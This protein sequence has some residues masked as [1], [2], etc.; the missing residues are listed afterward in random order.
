MSLLLAAA[1][2]LA[3]Q[4]PN[5]AP[6]GSRQFGPFLLGSYPAYNNG[7]QVT[8]LGLLHGEGLESFGLFRPGAVPPTLSPERPLLVLFHIYGGDGDIELESWTEFSDEADARHWYILAP[9][10]DVPSLGLS[11]TSSSLRRKTYGNVDAQD[12]LELTLRW[13]LD[14]YPIDRD[15]I[16]GVGFSMGGG[17]VVSYAAQH[18]DPTRGAFAAVATNAGTLCLTQEYWLNPS[19]REALERAVGG[20]TG[21]TTGNA[22]D[23]ERFSSL[24]YSD[25]SQASSLDLGRRHPI[26]NLARTPLQAWIDTREPSVHLTGFVDDIEVVL[27]APHPGSYFERHDVTGTGDPHRWIT[28]DYGAVCDTFATK[29]LVVPETA[30]LTVS[31]DARY[32]DLWLR[33]I[34]SRA[35]GEVRYDFTQVGVT[36]TLDRV[37]IT[38]CRNIERVRFD[39][40]VLG[41]GMTSFYEVELQRQQPQP[42]RLELQQV[43]QPIFVQLN[44]AS[45]G[46]APGI[47]TYDLAT[48]TLTLHSSAS[49]TDVWTIL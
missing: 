3:P 41:L 13:V 43:S 30:H 8:E 34:D 10:Q 18:L 31:R 29:Q 47:W 48:H 35:F 45:I 14:H 40:G 22:F 37:S 4:T 46:P 42:V 12:R 25:P 38:D 16:Y 27:G 19:S 20:G 26:Q 11:S 6:P 32:W 49:A 2:C 36:G 33:R 28:F 39:G 7:G 21:P 23:Y 9:D 17:D 1:L 44:G 24:L 5:T 15:R